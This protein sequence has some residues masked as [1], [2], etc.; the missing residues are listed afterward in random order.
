MKIGGLQKISLIDYPKELSAI[1]FTMGCN[2]RCP[3]CHNPELITGNANIIDIG[4][5]LDFLKS[6]V[7]KL[8]AVSITGGEP[9]LH[10]DLPVF[11]EQIKSMG[12]K[13][14][15]DTNGTNPDML[16]Q[17]INDKIVDYVAMDVKAPLD[18]YSAVAGVGVDVSNIVE[19]INIIKESDINYEYRTTIVESCLAKEDIVS[20]AKMIKGAKIYYLQRFIPSKTLDPSFLNKKTYEDEDL[21]QLAKVIMPHYVQ[22]C[23]VR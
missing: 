21:L 9:T 13:I 11:M 12:Y 4:M 18:K 6:R 3:Y 5:I 15:L 20:I 16:K 7:G 10:S 1:I 23:Y 22:S 14:K 19:S 2:F 17:I 8:S